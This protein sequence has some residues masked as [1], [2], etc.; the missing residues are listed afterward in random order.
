MRHEQVHIEHYTE[1]TQHK[2]V[3]PAAKK[4]HV[5]G[6]VLDLVDGWPSLS[7]SPSPGPTPLKNGWLNDTKGRLRFRSCPQPDNQAGPVSGMAAGRAL[8][9]SEEDLN[10]HSDNAVAL[11]SFLMLCG[12]NPTTPFSQASSHSVFVMTPS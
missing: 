5:D 7:L 10:E 9:P 2:R 6:T 8:L 12:S 3:G 4:E 1:Y 11:G